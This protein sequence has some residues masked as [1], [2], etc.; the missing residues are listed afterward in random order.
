MDI[1]QLH[2]KQL[3]FIEDNALKVGDVLLLQNDKVKQLTQHAQIL[4]IHSL[5]GW[6]HVMNLHNKTEE[7]NINLSRVKG[8]Y[9]WKQTKDFN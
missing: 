1:E 2:K 5:Y 4:H 6:V 7:L 9:V 8:V 3:Q